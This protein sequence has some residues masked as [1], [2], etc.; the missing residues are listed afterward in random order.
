LKLG[1]NLILCDVIYFGEALADLN[2]VRDQS[3]TDLIFFPPKF[4]FPKYKRKFWR[5]KNYFANEPGPGKFSF[6][7]QFIQ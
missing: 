4:S 2:E 6:F 5:E 7:T 3:Y 1:C